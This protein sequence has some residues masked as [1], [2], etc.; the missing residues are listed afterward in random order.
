MNKSNNL[1]DSVFNKP[2]KEPFGLEIT[3]KLKN[4]DPKSFYT[5]IKNL[6]IRGLSSM[7]KDKNPKSFYINNITSQHIDLMRRYMLSFGIDVFYNSYTDS[8]LDILFRD[9]LY[10]ATKIENLGI[11]VSINWKTNEITSIGLKLRKLKNK[12]CKLFWEILKK[13]NKVNMILKFYKPSELRDYGFITKSGDG[14]LHVIYFDFANQAKYDK[15]YKFND[16]KS[17]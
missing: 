12:E 7:V 13:H 10:E 16:K 4:T 6:Y 1:I 17:F 2:P 9:F 3:A 11:N 8:E 5:Y 15:K 14:K